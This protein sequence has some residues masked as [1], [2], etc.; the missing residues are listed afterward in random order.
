M[1]ASVIIP[2]YNR[3]KIIELT[4]ASLVGQDIGND[5]YEVIVIDDGSSD[6]TREVVESFMDKLN[7]IY[8]FQE[9]KGYRVALARNEGIRRASGEVLIFLDSGMVV[10]R[11]FVRSH[12]D[13]H[14]D[15]ETHQISSRGTVLIGYVYGYNHSNTEEAIPEYI[16]FHDPDNTLKMLAKTEYYTDIRLRVYKPVSDQIDRLPAPWT[17]FWTTNVSVGKKLMLEAGCFDEGYTTWGMEDIECGYRLF[18]KGAKFVM[19]RAACG[20]HY[21]HHRESYTNLISNERNKRR[22][23]QTYRTTETEL[24]MASDPLRFNRAY[25]DYLIFQKQLLSYP[26]YSDLLTAEGARTLSEVISG[27]KNIVF[28]CQE[29]YLLEVCGSTAALE[30]DPVL[31]KTAQKNHPEVDIQQLVGCRTFFAAKE[32]EVCLIAGSGWGLP[33]TFLVGMA[34]EAERISRKVYWLRTPLD[35]EVSEICC[36]QLKDLGNGVTL[37]EITTFTKTMPLY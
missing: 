26:R 27:R 11:S 28:G 37:H 7:L 29:G 25:E 23:Y 3:S 14:C 21:P 32:F 10:G 9:D 16:N 19:S 4:L 20:V 22:F 24:Y 35:V 6:N 34:R 1:K 13:A 30:K 33:Q 2:T 36:R 17:L 5:N 8:Y 31:A 18:R 15:K 12:Y